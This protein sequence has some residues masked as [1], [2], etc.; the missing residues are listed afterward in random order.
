M[1][2][3]RKASYVM[4]SRKSVQLHSRALLDKGLRSPLCCLAVR[5]QMTGWTSCCSKESIATFTTKGTPTEVI[6]EKTFRKEL[7]RLQAKHLWM[8]VKLSWNVLS[9]QMYTVAPTGK[10]REQLYE[11]VF[12]RAVRAAKG[13]PMKRKHTGP[14]H[15]EVQA[16]WDQGHRQGP[17]RWC[18]LNE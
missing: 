1:L 13:I 4:F 6:T 16:W 14:A 5:W 17:P 3:Y 7:R 10:L 12:N 8:E 18:I 15:R 11:L 9:G 2:C